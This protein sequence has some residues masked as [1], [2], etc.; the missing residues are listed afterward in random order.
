MNPRIVHTLTAAIS[1][2]I[3][4][5]TLCTTEEPNPVAAGTGSSTQTAMVSGTIRTRDG[6]PAAGA[7]VTMVPVGD[8]PPAG[9]GK[10][11]ATVDS[12]TTDNA[13]GYRFPIVPK[14]RDYNIF[15]HKDNK[16]SY[17]DSVKVDADEVRVPHDT[18]P[19]V[20]S[21]TGVVRLREEHDSRT[22]LILVYGANVFRVP[23]DYTGNFTVDNMARGAYHVKFLSTIPAT[24]RSTPPSRSSPTPTTHWR[25]HAGCGTGQ[26]PR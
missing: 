15:A 5:L 21:I 22:V 14:G 12:A 16:K 24:I 11:A 18:L 13:G 3:I 26:L 19:G 9:L 20:G 8:A 7:T 4:A 25:T 23:T 17:R 1:A 2:A 10:T 6:S